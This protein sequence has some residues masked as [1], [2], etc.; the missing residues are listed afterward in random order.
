MGGMDLTP[1]E[2]ALAFWRRQ[3]RGPGAGA[4]VVLHEEL[5]ALVQAGVTVPDAVGD[6]ARRSHGS[7]RAALESVA[8][9]LAR[10]ATPGEA[11]GADPGRFT[12][13][14]AHLI[15]TGD[16]TGRYD[17]AFADAAALLDEAR[18]SAQ[19]VLMAVLYPIFLLHF[20][21]GVPACAVMSSSMGSRAATTVAV[22]ILAGLW[23]A[24]AAFLTLHAAGARSVAYG[25]CLARAP[26]VAGL[27]RSGA[28]ARAARTASVLVGAGATIHDALAAAAE[29]SGNGWLRHDLLGASE[30]VRRGG[31]VAGAF[32]D[33]GAFSDDERRMIAT[34]ERSG[35]LET[36]L[37]RIAELARE[38]AEASSKRIAV[39]LPAVLT[40]LVGLWVLVTYVGLLSRSLGGF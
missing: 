22:T 23:V 32:T 2:L 25:R 11:F 35:E 27:V 30:R 14:E 19:R 38:R 17:R 1:R 12:P 8:S 28:V 16:L 15:A 20:A 18:R 36:V 31:D 3:I 5:R 33:V 9:E 4:R 39:L 6:L 10:G 13:L 24:F 29:C 21:I 34:G 26:G 7:R 40:A 37:A